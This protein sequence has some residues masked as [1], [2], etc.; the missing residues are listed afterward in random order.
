ME[1]EL[2]SFLS[3]NGR[4]SEQNQESFIYELNLTLTAITIISEFFENNF[5][6]SIKDKQNQILILED[7]KDIQNQTIYVEFVISELKKINFYLTLNDFIQFNRYDP[8]LKFYINEISYSSYSKIK[9]EFIV[10]YEAITNLI[11]GLKKKAK[12]LT[13]ENVLTIYL[14]Q[15]NSYVEIPIEKT[16]YEDLIQVQLA[17]LINQYVDNIDPIHEKSTIFIKE[18]IDFLSIKLK[19]D[20][21]NDLI[22]YFEEFY[23]KCNISYEY[24]LSNFTFNKIK[25]EIDNMVLE[26]SKNIRS[27]INDSQSK[28]IA[29]PAAFILG[30]SQINYSEPLSLKNVLIVMSEFLFSYIITIFIQNQKNALVIISDNLNN[31]KE[32]FQRSKST[33]FDTEKDLTLL[34]GLINKS[35]EKTERELCNQE[36][37]LNILNNCNWGISYVLLFSII[38][39][40]IFNYF[41]KFYKYWQ[42]LQHK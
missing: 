19:K 34:S 38:F 6:E 24:Y 26:Y 23:E 35:F 16:N 28:L 30:V 20:R 13:E 17:K 2:E 29:I 1:N 11:Q 15:E 14:I 9:N 39:Y 12:F 21:F 37:S 22:K 8:P 25:L 4:I 5:I 10:K 42:F 18:L 41:E 36:K 32:Y 3:L 31:F 7:L 33:E 40:E 27:I